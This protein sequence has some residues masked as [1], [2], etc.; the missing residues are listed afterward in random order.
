M[1]L[2]GI[3]AGADV[4]LIAAQRQSAPGMDAS[5]CQLFSIDEITASM[6]RKDFGRARPRQSEPGVSTCFYSGARGSLTV[7][8]NSNNPRQSFDEFKKLLTD[9]GEKLEPIQGLGDD[10]FFFGDRIVVR[11]GSKSLTMWIGER[12]PATSAKVRAGLTAL[13]KLGVPKLR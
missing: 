9:S 6:D 1:L 5:A 10:A 4:D 3:L 7:A 12:S 2:A 8:V 11:T 13:A